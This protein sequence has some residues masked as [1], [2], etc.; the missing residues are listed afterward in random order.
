MTICDFRG[1]I[2]HF[3][4][5]QQKDFMVS[6][7]LSEVAKFGT[8]MPAQKHELKPVVP[9]CIWWSLLMPEMPHR[10]TQCIVNVSHHVASPTLNK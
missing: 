7:R 3:L 8:I 1:F 5:K 10:S 2:K 4:G 9:D 6:C